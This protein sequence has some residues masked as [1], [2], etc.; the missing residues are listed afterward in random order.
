[1]VWPYED[2]SASNKLKI[3]HETDVLQGDVADLR[4]YHNKALNSTEISTIMNNFSTI[5]Q[6]GC[7]DCPTC[8][9]CSDGYYYAAGV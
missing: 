4:Y 6:P 3:G 1:M 9:S 7:Q 5:C 8:S 2:P